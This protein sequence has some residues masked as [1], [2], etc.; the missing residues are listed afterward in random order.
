M[1]KLLEEKMQKLLETQD[2]NNEAEYN[3]LLAMYQ[4]L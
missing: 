2:P 4:K 1:K 3:R